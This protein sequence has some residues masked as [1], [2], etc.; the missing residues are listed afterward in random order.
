MHY[1]LFFEVDGFRFDKH[2]HYD[3]D[4]TKCPPWD[5]PTE[6]SMAGIFQPPP[7][8]NQLKSKV[9]RRR[10]ACGGGAFAAGRPPGEQA[11]RLLGKKCRAG[12]GR[13]SPDCP[14]WC[15]LVVGG[16]V[17]TQGKHGASSQ[18]YRD[19]LAVETVATLNA[20]FC[21]YH[22]RHCPPSQQLLD[23]CTGVRPARPPPLCRTGRESS[24]PAARRRGSELVSAGQPARQGAGRG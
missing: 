2:W 22:L 19:L 9:R 21:D 15:C 20:A 4:V 8:P 10:P 6:K 11:K 23:T 18:Y 24:T 1:G 17:H 3:F 14:D 16:R 7:H 12:G 13:A 5:P